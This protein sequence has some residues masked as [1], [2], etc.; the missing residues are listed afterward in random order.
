LDNIAVRVQDL[1][2]KFGW[3]KV[4]DKIS[5][6]IPK[7]SKI[8]LVGPNGAGK[9]TLI[10]VLAGLELFDTGSVVVNGKILY[11]PEVNF[12][13]LTARI[14]DW[15]ELHSVNPREFINMSKE[16]GVDLGPYIYK[17]IA[18]LSKGMRRVLELLTIIFVKADIVLLDE[19]F[20]GIAPKVAYPL[21]KILMGYFEK[22]KITVIASSHVYEGT[23]LLLNPDDIFL[24]EDGVLRKVSRSSNIVVEVFTVEGVR[25]INVELNRVFSIL[26]D[27][28][29]GL[30][31][32]V[33]EIRVYPGVD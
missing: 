10:R 33:L 20:T 13:P 22:Q 19:P 24:L 7:G 1:S 14:I 8:L 17:P 30:G 23:S 31:K 27:V 11:V 28:L 12:A 18:H 29:E 9:T 15:L 25:R 3:R 32:W 6:T 2:K 16:C 26:S 5:F 21:S 4:L